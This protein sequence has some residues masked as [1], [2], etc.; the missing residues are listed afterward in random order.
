[1]HAAGDVHD[2]FG[3][4]V[5]DVVVIPLVFLLEI[6][7][8]PPLKIFSTPIRPSTSDSRSRVRW[9]PVGGPPLGDLFLQ[10]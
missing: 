8:Y 1:M 2:S 5:D 7:Y 4:V 6:K 3:V 10:N 9:L